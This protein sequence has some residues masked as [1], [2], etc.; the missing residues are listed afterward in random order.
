MIHLFATRAGWSLAR[1]ADCCRRFLSGFLMF[2]SECFPEKVWRAAN[3]FLADDSFII[4]ECVPTFLDG[5]YV[6]IAL[7]LFD[8]FFCAFKAASENSTIDPDARSEFRTCFAELHRFF[9]RK[10]TNRRAVLKFA[11]DLWDMDA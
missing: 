8:L 6:P 2:L 4:A 9:A 10:Q 3:T 1:E 5:L 11:A 7:I